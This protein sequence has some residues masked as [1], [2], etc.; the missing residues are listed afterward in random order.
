MIVCTKSADTILHKAFSKKDIV[1]AS[2]QQVMEYV[3]IDPTISNPKRHAYIVTSDDVRNPQLRQQFLNAVSE[4]HPKSKIVFIDKASK[5]TL[6]QEQQMLLD[7]V[8]TKPKPKDLA[9]TISEIMS[10][11]TIESAVE[12]VSG[13]KDDYSIPDFE[14]EPAE[15]V[16]AP[17]E[18]T[19]E[20]EPVEEPLPIDTIEEEP[21]PQPEPQPTE[22]ESSLVKRIKDAM[23]VAD[24]SI[25]A[26]EIQATELI[27]DLINTS[28]SYAGIEEK[29]KS[30]NDAIYAIMNDTTITSIEEKLVKVRALLHDKAFFESKGGT[31]LEQRM[32]EVIDAICSQCTAHVHD[33]L[34]EIDTALNTIALAQDNA[35][36]GN[37]RLAGINE[38]RV[39]IIKELRMLEIDIVECMKDTDRIATS[40]MATLAERVVDITGNARLNEVIRARGNTIISEGTLAAIQAAASVRADDVSDEFKKMRLDITVMLKKLSKLFDLDR[41]MLAAQAATIQ[42]LRS[43]NV[44]DSVIIDSLLKKSLRVYIGPESVGRTIIP[45]LFSAYM[46]RQNANVLLVDI[47]GKAKFKQYD[48]LT[49]D[50]DVFYAQQPQHELCVVE[51]SIGD[52]I[53]AYQ[54]LVTALLKACDYYRIINIVMRDDQK[55]ALEVIA[56]DP[57]SINYITDTIPSH[58]ELTKGLIESFNLRNVGRRVIL[59]KCDIPIRPI[60]TKLGLDDALDTQISVIP[61]LPAITDANING[62]NPFGLS[63][64]TLAI[65]GVLKYVGH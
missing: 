5:P 60:V 25:V 41:E 51:G 11:D 37:A 7:A 6:S 42:F 15:P 63:S 13:R 53:T 45:Y 64:V 28:S 24:V 57:A 17:I 29:L 39:N 38:E 50:I 9:A 49:T 18:D 14:P 47:T 33:R 31:L 58:I 20:P 21:E 30:V 12:R 4:K 40:T 62:F 43:K 2:I 36:A 8:L 3:G 61:T 23:T 34:S 65:E 10:G 26:K 19:P 59:N 27:K 54:Q 48:I 46:S 22:E 55:E 52:S 16:E 35:M 44:E 32:E 1:M 56:D